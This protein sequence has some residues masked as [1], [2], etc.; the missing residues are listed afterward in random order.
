MPIFRCTG[1]EFIRDVCVDTHFVHRSRFVRLAQVIATNPGCTGI[2][3]EEDTAIIVH[4]G[5]EAEVIGSGVVIV[6]LGFFII[7][8]DMENFTAKKPVSVHNL[9]VDILT[10]GDKFHIDLANPPHK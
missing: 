1:L 2:G 9:K 8:S 4:N 7:Q 6:I 10:P 5:L 3:I